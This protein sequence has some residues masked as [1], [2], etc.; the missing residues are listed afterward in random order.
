M[1]G[2]VAFWQKWFGIGKLLH[3]DLAIS[4]EGM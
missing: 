2:A 3:A 4:V 1:T